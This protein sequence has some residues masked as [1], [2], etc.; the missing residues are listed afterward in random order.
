MRRN[1]QISIKNWLNH[2]PYNNQK[3][4]DSYFVKLSNKVYKAILSVDNSSKIYEYFDNEQIKHMSCFLV[5]YFEDLI[6]DSNIWNTFVKKHK[7]LYDKVLPFYEI[8]EYF[9][10]EINYYDVCFLIWYFISCD[11]NLLAPDE[12]FILEIAG[13]IMDIFEEEWETAPEN[14]YLKKYY[15]IENNSADYYEARKLIDNILFNSYLFHPD[16]GVELFIS[17]LEI[18]DDINNQPDEDILYKANLI[19]TENREEKLYKN[20]TKLLA[21]RGP[22]WAAELLG[23]DHKLSKGYINL[24]QKILG[25][26]FYK[27]EDENNVF[28]EHIA[29]SKEFNVTK[30]SFEKEFNISID[31]IVYIGLIKWQDEWW[32][33]GNYFTVPY[34][35]ETVSKERNSQ[36]SKRMISSLDSNQEELQKIIDRQLKIFKESNNN[37]TIV[38][39][40]ANEINN[41]LTNQINLFNKKLAKSTPKEK[42]KAN[43]D[44][45]RAGNTIIFFNEKSGIEIAMG[46]ISAF[47]AKKNPFYNEDDCFEDVVT[48]FTEKSISPEL[49]RYAIDNF[50]D[51]I[52]YFNTP[53]GEKVIE[54]LDFILR[55]YKTDN[56]YTK[57]GIAFN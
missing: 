54:N 4:T 32:F 9:E 6:S 15:T 26:F 56:Y 52:V 47:P 21:L 39:L 3:P 55:F 13:Y 44:M 43:I 5:S 35:S 49:V 27:G 24:S 8:D 57:P 28:L 41:F 51:K 1:R 22:E 19:L 46:V 20:H 36:D 10:N 7:E 16:T 25:L 30:K 12:Y 31:T 45:S 2:K 18:L 11:E 14:T 17:E 29:S 33:S 38:F 40:K 50:K 37:E 53:L 34:N 48:L 42:F 23:K